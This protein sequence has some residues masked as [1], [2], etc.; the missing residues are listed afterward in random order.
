MKTRFLFVAA[1]WCVAAFFQAARSAEPPAGVTTASD[2]SSP[3]GEKYLLRYKFE[4]GETIR[5]EVEHRAQ[6]RTTVS[7]TT[8]TAETVS[9]SVKVWQV[10]DV[11]SAGRATFV[12]SVESVDMRQKLTGRQEVSYNSTTDE[13]PPLGFE[14][15]AEAVGIPLA[16]ITL[17][18]QGKVTS[19]EDKHRPSSGGTGPVTIPLPSEALAVGQQWL[20]PS[21]VQ[22]NLDNGGVKKIQARQRF[23]LA[24]VSEGLATIRIETQILSPVHN[25]AIEAQLIQKESNGTVVFDIESGRIV[26]QQS[27]VDKRVHGVPNET[28]SLHC[29]TRFTEKLIAPAASNRGAKVSGPPAPPQQRPAA[30]VRRPSVRRAGR[31]LDDKVQGSGSKVQ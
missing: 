14:D 31:V 28:S 5:W 8:Q 16:I 29:L 23:T 26:S 9:S 21:E 2:P 24:E 11:D 4:P 6:I 17:D 3:L 12:H 7:G 19:R 1:A 13:K 20:L 10:S 25:P 22:V 27:D 18:A 30:A 15:V